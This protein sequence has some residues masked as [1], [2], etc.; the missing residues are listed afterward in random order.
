MR[1]RPVKERF[2]EKFR[3][4]YSTGCWEWTA[5][6]NA[7]G[8]GIIGFAGGSLLAHRVAWEIFFGEI[9]EPCVLH[10]C[11]NPG[12]VNPEH[13]FLG[14]QQDNIADMKEKGRARAPERRGED[15]PTSKL[16]EKQVLEIRADPRVQR[17]I[18]ADYG[19]HQVTVG[20]I[21]RREI[22]THI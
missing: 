21:K 11:D 16:T 15:V 8:Y 2:M 22:W 12:C 1:K 3:A 14:T 10:H 5:A 20:E 7:C 18:A 13:L 9:T 4:D 6:K 17:E 19:V